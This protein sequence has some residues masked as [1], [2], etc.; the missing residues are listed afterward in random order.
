MTKKENAP[1]L[2]GNHWCSGG[3]NRGAASVEARER[4]ANP[5]YHEGEQIDNPTVETK[6]VREE[7]LSSHF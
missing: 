1:V 7:E 5:R 2:N 6:H 4:F 3:D